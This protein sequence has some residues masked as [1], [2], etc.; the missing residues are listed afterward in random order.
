MVEGGGTILGS[1][2]DSGAVD[3]VFAFYAP[4]LI[5]GEKAVTIGGAG[6][7]RVIEALRLKNVSVRSFGDNVLITGAA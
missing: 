2:I 5:G 4:L 1:F 6:R 7:A 3:K